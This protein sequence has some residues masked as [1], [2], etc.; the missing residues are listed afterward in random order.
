MRSSSCST[1]SLGDVEWL[2]MGWRRA[3]KKRRN[4]LSNMLLPRTRVLSSI[5]PHKRGELAGQTSA[6]RDVP[7]SGPPARRR[8][9]YLHECTW[10]AAFVTT[11]RKKAQETFCAAIKPFDAQ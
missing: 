8:L 7:G 11:K 4:V 3:R 2:R 5:R 9:H 10:R 1:L 6:G